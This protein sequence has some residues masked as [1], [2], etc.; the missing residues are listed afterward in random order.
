[1]EAK[2]VGQKIEVLIDVEG[3]DA[4]SRSHPIQFRV[5]FNT[6]ESLTLEEVSEVVSKLNEA[7]KEYKKYKESMENLYELDGYVC[8]LQHAVSSMLKA[9]PGSDKWKE[10]QSEMETAADDL[11]DAVKRV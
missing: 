2:P 8:D 1:M 7:V 5:G 6:M 9:K 3:K 4:F 11:A 10:Q